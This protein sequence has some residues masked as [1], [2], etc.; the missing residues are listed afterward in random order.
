LGRKN[1]D[2]ESWDADSATGD[3]SSAMSINQWV[4]QE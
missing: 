1:V 2:D 3:D 4:H